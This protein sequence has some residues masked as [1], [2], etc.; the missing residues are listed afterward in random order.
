[1]RTNRGQPPKRYACTAESDEREPRNLKEALDSTNKTKWQN[2]MMEELDAMKANNTWD[3]VDLPAGRSP[4][5][6]KWVYKVKRDATGRITRYKARLVAKGFSQRYG[7]DY[8]EVFA[9]VVR[10]TTFRTLMSVAAKRGMIVKQY[11]VKTAFL[12]G[13]LTFCSLPTRST[14]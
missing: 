6:C 4:I 14:I 2:A 7:T 11:D 3:L 12:H 13:N 8:D 1:M 9:P 5:G 10:Q